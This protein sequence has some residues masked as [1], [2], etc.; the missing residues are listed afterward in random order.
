MTTVL[1]DDPSSAPTARASFRR[2]D[3]GPYVRLRVSY[4]PMH[5]HSGDTG[6]GGP[7]TPAQAVMLREAAEAGGEVKVGRGKHRTARKLD[8][9]GLGT[10]KDGVFKINDEGRSYTRFPPEEENG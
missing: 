6:W 1:A 4:Q 8:F 10:Y 9:Y 2:R 3:I 5:R 7:D